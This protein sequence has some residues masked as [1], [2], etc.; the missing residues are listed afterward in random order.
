M[1]PFSSSDRVPNDEPLDEIFGQSKASDGFPLALFQIVEENCRAG[2]DGAED[3]Q[4]AQHVRRL[5]GCWVHDAESW[6]LELLKQVFLDLGDIMGLVGSVAK[7][8]AELAMQFGV[9][10]CCPELRRL[11]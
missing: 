11:S 8:A 7:T 9:G 4:V 1:V 3:D 5:H 2:D 6:I 10:T